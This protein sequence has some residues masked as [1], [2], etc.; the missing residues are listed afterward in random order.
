MISVYS[1]LSWLGS[2]H[3]EVGDENQVGNTFLA[4]IRGRRRVT[5][6]L[7]LLSL[8]VACTALFHFSSI[9]SP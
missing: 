7:P 4:S 8:R 1:L 6:S 5:Y 2:I 9:A 3:L